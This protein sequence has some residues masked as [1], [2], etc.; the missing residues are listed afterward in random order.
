MKWF[1]HQC[2]ADENKKVRKIEVGPF[3]AVKT[4]PWPLRGDIGVS[5]KSLARPR[6]RRVN[7]K[8]EPDYDLDLVADD[9]R[10]SPK[11]LI[12]FCNLLAQINAIDSQLWQEKQEIACPKLAERC[13]EY[14][15]KKERRKQKRQGQSPDSVPTVLTISRE[16][17]A[18][19]AGDARKNQQH[20]HYKKT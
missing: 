5:W 8:F 7:L 18:T 10:C 2:D 12:E 20:L 14:S 13:D 19:G 1:Q 3:V 15:K 17:P 6:R 11:Y 9:L 16:Y 4:A